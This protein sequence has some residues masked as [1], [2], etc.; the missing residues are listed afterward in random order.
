MKINLPVPPREGVIAL[1]SKD[2]IPASASPS[3]PG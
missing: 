1:T 3:P 2:C